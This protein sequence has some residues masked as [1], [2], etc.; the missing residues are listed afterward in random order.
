MR[1]HESNSFQDTAAGCVCVCYYRLEFAS[2]KV[3]RHLP[4][5]EPELI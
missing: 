4:Y 3:W 1:G 5:T 2:V